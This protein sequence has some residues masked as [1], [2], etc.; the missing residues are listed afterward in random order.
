[1]GV[2]IDEHYYSA[3]VVEYIFFYQV[4]LSAVIRFGRSPGS[5]EVVTCD[6]ASR[7][8]E[9]DSVGVEHGY[10]FYYVVLE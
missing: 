5:V 1:M 8:A 3:L 2:E 6:V 7:I 10:Y 9:D 4:D